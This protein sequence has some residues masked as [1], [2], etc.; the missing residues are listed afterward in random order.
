MVNKQLISTIDK[1]PA[2]GEIEIKARVIFQNGKPTLQ[3]DEVKSYKKDT[4]LKSINFSHTNIS[5]NY[6]VFIREA[7]LPEIPVINDANK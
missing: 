3:L 4:D 5:D 2:N 6:K 1:L 7:S